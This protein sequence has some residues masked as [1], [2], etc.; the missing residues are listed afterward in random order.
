MSYVIKLYFGRVYWH[1]LITSRNKVIQNH[2]YHFH[3]KFSLSQ[4]RVSLEY[5]IAL[6]LLEISQLHLER[7]RHE[8][9]QPTHYSKEIF[10]QEN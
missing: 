5:Y 3:L 6:K 10:L 2:F 1:E 4:L 9:F 8:T 7:L